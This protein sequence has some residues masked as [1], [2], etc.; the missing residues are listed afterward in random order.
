LNTPFHILIK[1]KK[2]EIEMRGWGIPVLRA[3]PTTSLFGV[4][5]F[6]KNRRPHNST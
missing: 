1:E 4:L 3:T 2:T 5:A 6:C